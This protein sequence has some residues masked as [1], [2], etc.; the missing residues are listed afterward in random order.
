MIQIFNGLK[1]YIQVNDE[2]Q[3]YCSFIWEKIIQ[4]FEECYYKKQFLETLVENEFFDQFN[5]Q[6]IHHLFLPKAL[7][8]FASTNKSSVK[9]VD[10]LKNQ[11]ASTLETALEE[12]RKLND[13]GNKNFTDIELLFVEKYY[14]N[15][16]YEGLCNSILNSAIEKN[17]TEHIVNLIQSQPLLLSSPSISF[18]KVS[19]QMIKQLVNANPQLGGKIVDWLKNRNATIIENFLN[20]RKEELELGNS[21]LFS[22]IE[23][24]FVQKNYKNYADFCN[25]I[26]NT[27]IEKI[28]EEYIENLI[29][30][31]SYLLKILKPTWNHLNSLI[32][33]LKNLEN[34]DSNSNKKSI[35]KLISYFE[36]QNSPGPSMQNP[37]SEN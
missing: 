33:I 31:Q 24:L 28:N 25:L 19:Y 7:N 27:A 30:S 8:F 9:F 6:L 32:R 3:K 17:N 37:D 35:S 36:S 21:D 4:K 15:K 11:K 14:Q 13:L 29:Q 5:Y 16:N 20:Q 26:F 10:W 23:L 34:K 22:A 1:A 2:N 18:E 12:M